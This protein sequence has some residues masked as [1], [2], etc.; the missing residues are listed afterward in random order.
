MEAT[1][2]GWAGLAAS[3]VLVALALIL[4]VIQRLGLAFEIGWASVRAGAQLLAVGV[5]LVVVLDDGTPLALSWVWV[6][7]MIVFA[8]VTIRSSAR[9]V[10]GIL[11]ISIASMTAITVVSMGVIF[12]LGIFPHEPVAIVPVAGMLIGNSM[13]QTILA[14]N[15]VVAEIREKRD[16]VEARLALGHP[17]TIA[18][19]PYVAQALRT[20]LIPQ[21]ERTK[22]VGIVILPGAMTGLI[23]AGVD[24]TD[25]VLIQLAVMY[26]ILGSVATSVT[27]VGL[28]V[29]RRLFT[30]DHRLVS[31]AE[32]S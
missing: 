2:I 11:A 19:R 31:L 32:A 14:A 29:R 17:A 9:A 4:S 1:E 12:G 10:P 21:I 3:L 25:A 27:I 24:P 28:G 8:S 22:A 26:L 13:S 20:A 30:D 16:E 23:L 18:S 7:A 5:A 6:A 15:R